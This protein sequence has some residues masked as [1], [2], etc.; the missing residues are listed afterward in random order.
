[1]SIFSVFLWGALLLIGAISLYFIVMIVLVTLGLRNKFESNTNVPHFEDE[2]TE[3]NRKPKN[4]S[5]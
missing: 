1:M 3:N 5:D 4:E 2:S